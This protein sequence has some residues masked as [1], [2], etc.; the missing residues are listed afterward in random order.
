MN[1]ELARKTIVET[2][3]QKFDDARFLYFIRNL[4]NHLDESKK[5]TWTLKKAAFEDFVNHFTRLGTYT[6]PDGEKMDVLVIHSAQGH[7]PF[8]RARHPPQ[9]RRRLPRHR[10]RPGQGRRHRR[11]RFA[12]GRRLALLLR[13]TGLHI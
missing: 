3:R 10:P 11:I 9:F 12:A 4:V 13:Q 7:H 2:F 5:Q 6:D 1:P 8:A